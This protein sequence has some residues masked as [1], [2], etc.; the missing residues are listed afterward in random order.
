MLNLKVK[1]FRYKQV[2]P[3]LFRSLVV[4]RY[5]EAM[6][7]NDSTRVT[8]QA[9]DK[10]VHWGEKLHRCTVCNYFSKRIDNLQKHMRIHSG[11]KSQKSEISVTARTAEEETKTTKFIFCTYDSE[12]PYQNV[13]VEC[14]VE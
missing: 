3:L 8:S 14:R 1:V 13:W 6:Y 4:V 7:P 11:Q 5:S 2:G 9:S 12:I 10:S